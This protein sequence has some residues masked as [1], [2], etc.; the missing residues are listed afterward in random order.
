MNKF[1][2]NFLFPPW[3][4][5]AFNVSW[6][7]EWDTDGTAHENKDEKNEPDFIERELG[8]GFKISSDE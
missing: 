8:T 5:N 3:N 1:E 6:D 7:H 4:C 2:S